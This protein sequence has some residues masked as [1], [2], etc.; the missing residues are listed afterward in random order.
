MAICSVV[1]VKSNSS[2]FK[3]E[4]MVSPFIK[5]FVPATLWAELRDNNEFLGEM[6]KITAGRY[7]ITCNLRDLLNM[8]ENM[9][10]VAY[11]PEEETRDM[12]EN[13][14]KKVEFEPRVF[15]LTER[16]KFQNKAKGP[17]GGMTERYIRK[18]Q[19]SL[20]LLLALVKVMKTQ[21][22]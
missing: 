13:F 6:E 14:F 15:V 2:T 3:G 12:P 4:T 20:A 16:P 8:G 10:A 11:I 17:K 9:S 1:E 19:F 18:D 5:L 21:F 22:T 7:D